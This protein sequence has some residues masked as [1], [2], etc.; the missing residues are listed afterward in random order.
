MLLTGDKRHSMGKDSEAGEK[1]QGGRGIV[2]QGGTEHRGRDDK[3]GAGKGAEC[4]EE[5][6][7]AGGEAIL[8]FPL[9]RN[10]VLCSKKERKRR[11]EKSEGC[12][13]QPQ[14]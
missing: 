1:Q 7:E 11:L 13:E 4:Q 8:S 12:L 10:K 9:E 14:A 5:C 3:A 6:R 2:Q